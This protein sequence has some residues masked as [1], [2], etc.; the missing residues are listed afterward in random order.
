MAIL[1][2]PLQGVSNVVRFNWPF[3]LLAAGLAVAGGLVALLGPVAIR[4]YASWGLLLLLLPVVASLAASAWVYDFSNLYQL[5]WLPTFPTPQ[6]TL[7]SIN[8]GFDEISALLAQQYTPAQLIVVDFYNSSQ[9]TEASIERARRAYPPYPGTRLIDTQQ[10][11]PLSPQSVDYTFAFLAAHE[12][13]DATER[14]TFFQNLRRVTKPNGCIIVTE[15]LRDPA[16]FLAYTIGFL[17]FH[18][19]CTWLRT[20][21]QANLHLQQ[22]IRITPFITS[23]I[24]SPHGDAT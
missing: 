3:Y 7:L 8:A 4:G 11:L 22:E 20:F 10:P 19:R 15:H 13:R 1:R 16:N 21:A 2:K 24:L 17:H 18:S 23:F 9:H 14:A 5:N 12:I 6:A